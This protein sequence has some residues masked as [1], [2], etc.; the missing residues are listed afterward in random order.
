ML[1]RLHCTPWVTAPRPFVKWAGGKSQLLNQLCAFFPKDFGTYYEPFLGGAAVFFNLV[2]DYQFDAVLSDINDELIAAYRAIKDDCEKVIILLQEHKKNYIAF[3]EEYY[4]KVVASEPTDDVDKAARIIFLNRTCFNGL[5]RVNLKGRFNVPLG[6]YKNPRICDPD[7]LRAVSTALRWSK[8]KL[9]P[10]D[11]R[12][13]VKDAKEGDFIYFDPPYNPV[14]STASFTGY[15]KYRFSLKEQ[16]EL[17]KLFNELAQ[18]GCYV[19]LS[20]SNTPEIRLLYSDEG[21]YVKVVPALRAINC[22]ANL[23]FAGHTELIISNFVP[24]LA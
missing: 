4:Y 20:N 2:N 3:K 13:T 21:I 15:T 6:Q 11:F 24:R 22:K 1:T 10:L 23:R 18:R 7:N 19:L 17:A 12:E 16:K 14:S 8:T 5:Y 9:L